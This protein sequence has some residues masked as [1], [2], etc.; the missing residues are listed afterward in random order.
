M[1]PIRDLP[2]KLRVL[3]RAWRTR[4]RADPAQV[5]FILRHLEPGDVAVDVGSHKGGFTYWMRRAV[6]PTGRVY[7]FEPQPE[8]A[9]YQRRVAR[10]LA[11]DNVVVETLAL[12]SG[13][14]TATFSA[15]P[16]GF[17]AGGRLGPT[18]PAAGEIS[19]EVRTETLDHYFES[20]RR[21][22]ALIKI[23][24]E[25]HEREILRGARRI[26]TEDRPFLV[27]ECERHRHPG[28][29]IRPILD[30]VV[31]LGYSGSFIQRSKLVDLSRFDEESH[32]VGAPTDAINFAFSPLP[33]RASRDGR[34]GRPVAGQPR[35]A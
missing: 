31:E 5:R 34:A 25:G 2:L 29:T 30:S 26:L 14:G 6:G 15:V 21:P 24:A 33:S 18:Q 7:A 17:H 8:S 27:F 20:A 3:H 4:V 9:L 1:T 16:G 28:H 10:A 32:Q 12:S 23:D 13:R 19:F 11:L 22:V 35:S